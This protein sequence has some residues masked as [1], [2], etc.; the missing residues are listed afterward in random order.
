M[1][2][3]ELKD[4]W[5]NFPYLLSDLFLFCVQYFVNGYYLLLMNFKFFMEN[6][7][8]NEEYL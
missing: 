1:S 4:L 3:L 5:V 6:V 8:K 7:S 2:I